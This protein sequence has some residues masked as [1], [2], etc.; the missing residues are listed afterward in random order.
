ME[1]WGVA[2]GQL[3]Y[4]RDLVDD[5][6]HRVRTLRSLVRLPSEPGA[7]PGTCRPWVVVGMSVSVGP[8]RLRPFLLLVGD[9]V[10]SI[11]T[12][13]RCRGIAQQEWG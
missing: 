13:C 1:T 12:W 7:E 4:L 5:L 2:L 9:V 11:S 6:P 10:V 3:G 8:V